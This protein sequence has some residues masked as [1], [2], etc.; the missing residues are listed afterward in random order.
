MIE[1]NTFHN[2]D[3]AECAARVSST[4][5]E[6]PMTQ[7]NEHASCP[8]LTLVI[9]CHNE[10]L[11]LP[12]TAKRLVALLDQLTQEALIA[13][14]SIF[15]TDDGSTDGTWSAIE[16]LASECSCIHGLKLSRNFG[17]QSAILAGLLTA[18]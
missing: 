10:E 7:S 18:P 16:R 13:T 3:Y 12:E 14:P 8:R 11:V 6:G 17:Q 5:E 15:F 9:P 4:N 1:L 2:A